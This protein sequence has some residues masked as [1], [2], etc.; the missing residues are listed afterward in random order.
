MLVTWGEGVLDLVLSS[1]EHPETSVQPVFAPYL[2]KKPD[3]LGAFW[4]GRIRL[5]VAGL[6]GPTPLSQSLAEGS[7]IVWT[8]WNEGDVARDRIAWPELRSLVQRFLARIPLASE[9]TRR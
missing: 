8:G 2:E 9:S 5:P 3:R 6:D 1:H 7:P 4:P